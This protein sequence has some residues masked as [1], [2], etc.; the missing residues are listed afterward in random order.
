M[1]KLNLKTKHLKTIRDIIN[2]KVLNF[3][4]GEKKCF[5]IW[6]NNPFHLIEQD[7]FPKSPR[8]GALS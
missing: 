4:G 8:T 1:T 3:V 6:K 5:Q 2:E 7:L